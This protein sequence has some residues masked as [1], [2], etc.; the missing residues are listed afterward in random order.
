M[1]R[2]TDRGYYA[3]LALA[4]VATLAILTALVPGVGAVLVVLGKWLMGGW[5]A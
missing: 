2:L 1:T 5:V 3:V 4:V